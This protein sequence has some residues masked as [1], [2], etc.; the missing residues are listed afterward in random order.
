MTGG[1]VVV[2]GTTGRNFAAG[3][4]GGIA[5]IL[6]LHDKFKPKC[7]SELV[8]LETVNDE[9]EV[10]WLRSII[11]EHRS[12]T[13]SKVADRCLRNW[14]RV[15]PKFVKVIP[16]DYR[17][18]LKKLQAEIP[19]PSVVK[20]SK[21]EPSVI[22]I[23]DNIPNETALVKKA[24]KPPFDK[25]RGFMKYARQSDTYRSSRLR[26][27][28]WAEVNS[29]LSSNELKVQAARCMDCGVPFCQS[30]TG[31]PI[32]NII[33][34]WNDLVFKN[35]WLEALERLLMTNNFRMLFF[36]I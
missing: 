27:K 5:Y 34:Q 2:L 11:E 13:G 16:F 23:E 9:N 31:C 22:D 17:E 14:A 21:K 32:G 29:R 1:R 19:K 4:S 8:D 33:P 25:V 15:L 28:D 36:N 12:K 3:M 18:A 10:S 35:Q 26:I 24:F 30:D 20:I 6:D 7:N